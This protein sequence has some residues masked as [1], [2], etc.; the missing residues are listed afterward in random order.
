MAFTTN[1]EFLV[2]DRNGELVE[3]FRMKYEGGNVNPLAVFD[4]EKNRNYR[5]VVTQGRAVFM[6]D[7]QGK[8]VEGFTY[9]KA[10]DAII[11]PPKHFKIGQNDYLVFQLEN[12][13]LKIRH[14]AGG[15]R[16]KVNRTIPFS[17]NEVFFYKNKF[18]VTDSK[19]ILH[20]VDTRG[21]LSATNFNLSES[22]GMFATSKT[23]ALMDD[24]TLNIKGKKVNL[25]L[26]VYTSPKIFYINDK[27]YVTVTDIQNQKVYLFDSQAKMIPNF[28]VYGSSTIDLLDMDK[29]GKLELVAK[30]RDNSLIVYSL[31]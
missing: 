5:F 7:N 1:N 2:L 16:I 17:N 15:E 19:G 11:R 27:I 30:D 25:E 31:N 14:R 13:Q 21:K 23:L 3:P 10:E 28:P 18:S 26:G 4:Y 6:Y 9:T 8:I 12:G 20:Q 22:H 29:D 24:N